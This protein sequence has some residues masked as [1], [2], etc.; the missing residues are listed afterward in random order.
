MSGQ[1]VLGFENRDRSLRFGFNAGDFLY[2]IGES[3]E[4]PSFENM[5]W[6]LA[7]ERVRDGSLGGS[8][9]GGRH[10]F[11]RRRSVFELRL[12]VDGPVVMAWIDGE[13]KG[14][15][16]TV[17]GAPIE[18]AIG[19]A[20][21]MGAIH[22]RG[23]TVRRLD[24]LRDAGAAELAPV[25]VDLGARNL[26]TFDDLENRTLRGLAPPPN[27]LLLV[28]IPADHREEGEPFDPAR[29]L[30]RARS[31][32]RDLQRQLLRNNLPQQF[33]LVVPESVGPEAI[34]ALEAELA[35]EL[36]RPPRV[37]THRLDGLPRVG[38]DGAR[39]DEQADLSKRWLLY[40]D[41]RNVL[42][43][44]RPFLAQADELE[45]RLIHWLDV[46]RDHGRPDRDLPEPL[47]ASEA[48]SETEDEDESR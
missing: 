13:Y 8:S 17:D 10:E 4:E 26:P 44:A 16:H 14:R 32:A 38:P 37:R 23:V 45:P 7:G 20:T 42:R 5:G 31:A 24:R 15:Y 47:R 46:F 28:W 25:V 27:G 3:D 11:G 35:A 36:E 48:E 41:G 43:V 2:A 40:V 21:S 9:R 22:V 19:F 29:P 33:E 6:S 39:A 12:L 34:Q 18:G 1:V 30:Q